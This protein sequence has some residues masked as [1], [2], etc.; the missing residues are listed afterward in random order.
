ML[1]DGQKRKG[2][3]MHHLSKRITSQVVRLFRPMEVI[4]SKG[5]NAKVLLPTR[6]A[7]K[8]WS[9]APWLH[10]HSSALHASE[11]SRVALYDS[12]LVIQIGPNK[13]ADY[14][15]KNLQAHTCIRTYLWVCID[16][17]EEQQVDEAESLAEQP[18]ATSRS[19]GSFYRHTAATSTYRV[20]EPDRTIWFSRVEE[21]SLKFVGESVDNTR[22]QQWA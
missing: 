11:N 12:H 9:S 21:H 16:L 4:Y 19:T 3:I 7:I 6:L 8:Q 2:E 22:P 14:D 5:I 17:G 20:A 15:R 1:V 10:A 13:Y 18:G